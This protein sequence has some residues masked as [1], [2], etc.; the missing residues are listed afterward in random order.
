M[1]LNAFLRRTDTTPINATSF[2]KQ[3]WGSEL[4]V[5]HGTKYYPAELPGFCRMHNNE[6]TALITY[7][8]SGSACEVVTLNSTAEGQGI[9]TSLMR[10]VEDE[11]RK[12]GCTEVW[13]VTTNDNERAIAFYQKLGYKLVKVHEGTVAKSRK[14]KPEIPLYGYNGIEIKDELE[15]RKTL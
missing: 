8:I 13:L 10:Q 2:I 5:V 14:I 1:K 7:H 3:H 6:L 4:V 15:F 11:A 12:Q 9:G